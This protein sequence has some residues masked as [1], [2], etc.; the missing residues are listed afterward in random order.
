MQKRNPRITVVNDNPDF[1]ELMHDL[2]AKGSGYDVTTI[3]GDTIHDDI[4]PIRLSRPDL[5]I[6]DLRSR[7]GGLAGWDV[8]QSA[9][10]DAELSEVPIILCTG[11]LE[12]LE[13]HAAEIDQ[14]PKVRS[15]AKPFQVKEMENLVR[16]FVGEAAPSNQ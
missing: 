8:L 12:A 15:L 11:D 2:L 7:Q 16:Q 13:A 3:D 1:L 6:I 10:S 5:L 14:D 4:E 9:R